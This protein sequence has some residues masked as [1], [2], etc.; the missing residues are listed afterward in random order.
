[1]TDAPADLRYPIGEF[2]AAT[3][4]TLEMRSA[5]IAAIEGLPRRMREAVAGL[6]D[7]QLDTRYRPGGWTV[8]QVVHHVADSHMNALIRVKLALTEDR[9]TIKPYDE[10]AWSALPDAKL[11][12]AVSLN[13]IDGIHT[14]WVALVNG[15]AADQ[16]ARAFIHP[17]LKTEMTVDYHL[18]LYAWHSQ[19][20]VAH[21]TG[22]R[23]RKG[24]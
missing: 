16:F 18:Q 10:N 15:M 1:M 2:K 24:W 11:P 7:A 5:A 19:H 6:N 21:I 17:E 3:P 13:L 20:H 23:R 22:L 8:R 12:I 9:P 4:I 14:R